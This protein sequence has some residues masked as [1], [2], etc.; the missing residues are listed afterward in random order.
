LGIPLTISC[1][2]PGQDAP[3][4][5]TAGLDPTT[6]MEDPSDTMGDS[7]TEPGSGEATMGMTSSE[8]AD[9]TGSG[10]AECGNR[11]VEGDE[12]CDDGPANGDTAAC[13]A[14][15]TLASCGDGLVWEGEEE[16]DDGDDDDSDECPTTCLDATCGD[17][18]VYDGMEECDAGGE[19]EACDVDCTPAACGD[20][21][22]NMLAG[23]ECDDGDDDDSDE[24][25][26]TCLDATCGD[27]FIETEEEE[28][29]SEELGNVSCADFGLAGE[30][31]CTAQCGFDTSDCFASGCPDGG[32]FV[33]GMCW[34]L[35]AGCENTDV[36]CASH[37]LFGVGGPINTVWDM[38]TMQAIAGHYGWGVGGDIACCVEFGWVENSALFT[39]NFGPQFWN[40][41]G[42]YDVFPTVKACNPP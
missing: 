41:D 15:C 23:E 10:P 4:T 28:C 42:C 20:G 27:G 14:D 35:S 22:T 8:P 7:T 30:L 21:V 32:A 17:G 26:T 39:H 18:H 3:L 19:S 11:I 33:N 12:E 40:W 9:S 13:K 6:G 24:C 38:P 37:G 36:T 1:F 16:C 25:P 5:T 31:A 2:N 29:D 34:Y